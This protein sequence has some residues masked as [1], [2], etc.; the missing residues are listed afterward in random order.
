MTSKELY[1]GIDLGTV[2]TTY[3]YADRSGE[4]TVGTFSDGEQLMPSAIRFTNRGK[5]VGRKAF[6]GITDR[7]NFAANFKRQMGTEISRKVSD[8]IYSPTE[9][10]AIV[11]RKTLLDYREQTGGMARGAVISVPGDYSTP[12]RIATVDAARVAG[13][14]KV[15][16][17]NESTAAG[18]S[19]A[20]SPEGRD[21]NVF[22]VFDLGGGTFDATVMRREGNDFT[23]LSNEG[24]N[25]IGGKDWDL[26]LAGIIQK[27]AM[28]AANLT[29][30]D[31]ERDFELRRNI[32]AE[33]KVQKEILSDV[34]R[35]IS[36]L[37]V[38][39]R[40]IT[41]TVW[42]EEFEL[43]TR[44]LMDKLISMSYAALENAKVQRESLETVVL[45]GGDSLMTQMVANLDDAFPEAYVEHHDPMFSVSKGSAI[46]SH[47][48]HGP[49]R[50]E[51]TQVLNKSY[52]IMAGLDGC[53]TICNV[54]YR[55]HPLPLER[56]IICRPKRDEQEILSL[57]VYES[58]ASEGQYEST[59]ADSFMVSEHG[60]PLEGRISRGRTKLPI[61]FKV[62]KDG[63]ISLE[64]EC[65]GNIVPCPMGSVEAM[66]QE[67]MAEAKMKV[68]NIV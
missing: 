1:L 59:E 66:T 27:K 40:E 39:G 62:G 4:V 17:I 13:L 49:G 6:S 11:I 28:D 67:E 19:F 63:I 58:M 16:L 47:S 60:L 41:F 20:E 42:R 9:M 68:M 65:N 44:P 7:R 21:K 43:A 46:Y 3:S 5:V 48:V 10:S 18:L 31:V 2:N 24:S 14:D 15:A 54:V 25:N 55:N 12:A 56:K 45:V 32:L 35:S 23:V 22:M 37:R 57:M 8:S 34:D 29:L 53:E 64:V 50:M 33:A 61:T 38:G 30:R 26:E 36:V 52:G 51:V